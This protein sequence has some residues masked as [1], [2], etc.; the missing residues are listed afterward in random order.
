[1]GVSV[2]GYKF[3]LPNMEKIVVFW[4]EVNWTYELEEIGRKGHH[5]SAG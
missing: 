5:A 4:P 1:M 3:A 2:T